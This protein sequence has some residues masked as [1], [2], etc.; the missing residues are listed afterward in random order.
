[1]DKLQYIRE[2]EQLNILLMNECDI[3]FYKE[4][5]NTQFLENNEEYSLGCKSFA[6]DGSGGEYV[7]LED[8]SIGFIGSEGEVGRAAESL[9]EL[10]TFLIHTGCISDFSCKHIYKN[11]ELLKT[12][13]N[14]YISKIRERY[15]A[16]N[17][18]WDKVRSDIANSLSLVFSPDKLENVTMK[19]Y[20]AA[21]R[22][23][24]FSCK[25]LDGK[26]EYICDSI[27]SDIVGVWITELVGMSREE[28]ENYNQQPSARI[29]NT[30]KR[31]G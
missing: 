25:Y 9:D 11:K 8:G 31:Q 27:L 6:Q 17:K 4:T 7:F 12:Y 28:I 3:Y 14:G 13:C 1:M 18:D 29:N 21:T 2:N 24:I 15:K 10:L 23:P 5:G 16:Q 30:D 22:E 20:K 19:F 26:E